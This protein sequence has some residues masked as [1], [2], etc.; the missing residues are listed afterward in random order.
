MGTWRSKSTAPNP[1]M[2]ANAK[3]NCS[4]SND[5]VLLLTRCDQKKREKT[6]AERKRSGKYIFF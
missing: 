3:G 2:N 1:E 4:R 5:E 6:M